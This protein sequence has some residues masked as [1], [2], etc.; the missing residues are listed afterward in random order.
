MKQQLQLA[1][2]MKS[3]TPLIQGMGPMLQS[4]KEMMK[5]FGDNKQ[6]LGGILKL[7]DQLN[8]KK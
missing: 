5:G 7:A 6:D 8:V 4:A 2:S 3:M 1:E